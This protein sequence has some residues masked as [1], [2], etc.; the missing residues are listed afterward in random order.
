MIFDQKSFLPIT[1]YVHT[2]IEDY[3]ACCNTFIEKGKEILDKKEK[4]IISK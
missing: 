2:T 3:E 4:V 1:S